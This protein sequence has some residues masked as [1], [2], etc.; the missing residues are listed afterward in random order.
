MSIVRDNLMNDPCYS[1]YCGNEKC[2][3]MPRTFWYGAQF[4]CVWCGWLSS[5]PDDFIAEYKAKWGIK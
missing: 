2:S 4:K 5:F 3:M 1:P